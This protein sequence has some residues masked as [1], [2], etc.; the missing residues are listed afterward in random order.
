[1]EQSFFHPST[2]YGLVTRAT[3]TR[4]GAFLSARCAVA[5]IE[6]KIKINGHWE[7]AARVALPFP[8]ELN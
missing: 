8:S 5:V 2:T 6:I 7:P 3:R 1:M 4:A